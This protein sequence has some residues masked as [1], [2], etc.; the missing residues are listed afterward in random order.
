MNEILRLQIVDSMLDD[1]LDMA[2]DK[3][4][5]TATHCTVEH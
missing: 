5:I 3:S 4:S 2:A 1:Q